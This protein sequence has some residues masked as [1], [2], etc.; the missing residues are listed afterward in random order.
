MSD[1]VI[2]VLSVIFSVL[3]AGLLI[4]CDRLQEGRV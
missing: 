4:L 3:T 1:V 2:L